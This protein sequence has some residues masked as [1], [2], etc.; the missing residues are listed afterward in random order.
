[1]NE[2]RQR[3][4]PIDAASDDVRAELERL[5][6]AIDR[7]DRALLAQLNERARLVERV[8]ELKR[9][10]GA[11]V[12]D[13]ARERDLVGCLIAANEGPFPDAGLGPVFREIVSAT[14]SLEAE[15][16][17]AFLGPEA[18]FSHLAAQE[19]FGA[20]AE[21]QAASTIPEVFAAVERGVVQHGVVPVENTTEGVVT[22]TLDTLA[23]STLT[24]CGE[25]LLRISHQLLSR[26]GRL[27]DV[28]RVASHPQPLA[29]CRGWLDRYLP[30]VPRSETASTAV[31]ARLAAEDPEVAAIASRLAGES[32]GLETIAP[33][34]EDR[35]DNTTRFLILG[36]DPPEPTG[37]DVT[38]VVFTVRKAEPG[39]LK[40]LLDPF[41]EHGVNLASI[42][43]R[44]QKDTPW[45][46]LFFLD[47]EGHAS[48]PAMQR[49]LAAAAR[50]AS[51]HR[52]LGCFPRATTSRGRP[53]GAQA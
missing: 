21:Y 18:T 43:S 47:L 24:I 53:G 45:E 39:A 9:G 1:M 36:G 27:E 8:G 17:V 20:L 35:R 38:S 23:T 46:Y 40:R 3:H 51:S 49:A 37:S 33:S 50:E 30:G 11:G 22:A 31:A 28:K 42:Q 13:A 14:R 19:T 29:Q 15:L 2:P 6:E 7:T 44:P 4:S 41:S 26:S 16:R 32:E 12:Y 25:K 5:R 48:E 52:V 10:V 34:I